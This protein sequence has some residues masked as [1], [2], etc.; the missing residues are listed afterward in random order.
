MQKVRPLDR[1]LVVPPAGHR[2][3]ETSYSAKRSCW[4]A[5]GEGLARLPRTPLA[6]RFLRKP[7]AAPRQGTADQHLST[8]EVELHNG[9]TTRVNPTPRSIICSST[10]HWKQRTEEMTNELSL[11]KAS[12]MC[13]RRVIFRC[14]SQKLICQLLYINP[15]NMGPTSATFILHQWLN[16]VGLPL[17][18][19]SARHLLRF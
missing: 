4:S 14:K 18:K 2:H 17:F 1:A 11:P 9:K 10:P 13:Q 7:P 8:G 6:R 3:S 5:E 15:T 12:G 19:D 16:D